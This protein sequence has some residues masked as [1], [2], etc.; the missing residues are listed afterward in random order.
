MRV[1]FNTDMQCSFSAPLK[2]SETHTISA[3]IPCNTTDGALDRYFFFKSFLPQ[4]GHMSTALTL[5]IFFNRFFSPPHAMYQTIRRCREYHA[6]DTRSSLFPVLK[7]GLGGSICSGLRKT[8]PQEEKY[9][10]QAFNQSDLLYAECLLGKPS[11]PSG[12]VLAGLPPACAAGRCS[13]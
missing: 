3:R 6:P 4:P 13:S 1:G 5:A 11:W 12:Q 8:L 10:Q 2:T 9:L 7:Q